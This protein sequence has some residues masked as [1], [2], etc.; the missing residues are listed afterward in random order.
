MIAVPDA[1]DVLE[2]A[3]H[4]LPLQPA[5]ESVHVTPAFARSFCTV[6][7]KLCVSFAS[8]VLLVGVMLT[9][10]GAATVIAAAAETLLLLTDVAVRVTLGG[11][12]ACFGAA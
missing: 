4:V 5:P 1:L 12:G 8:T 3:P 7:V 2:S 6:A 11:F 10:I 9:D